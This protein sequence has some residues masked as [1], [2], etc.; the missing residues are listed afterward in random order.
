MLLYDG[1]SPSPN[2][3]PV[4]MFVHERGG[5]AFDTQVVGLSTLENRGRVYRETVNKRGEMPALRL[6]DGQVITEITAICEYLDERASGG[7][8]LIGDTAEQRAH[9]RM[10]TRRID[11]EIAEPAVA[12]WRGSSDAEDY[13]MGFRILAPESQRYHRL[14]AEWGL[15]QLNEDIEGRD[16]ICGDRMMLADIVL[17]GFMFNLSQLGVDW[18]NNPNRKNV[19]AWFDRVQSTKSAKAALKPF[20][21]ST[22]I[23]AI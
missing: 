10:W 3:M 19:A 9:V 12:Y 20:A 17:F 5:L 21:A 4:R 6:D 22:E 7:R 14:V 16:F 1:D 15:N 11:L 18:I 8:S 23:P 13:Y 2:V